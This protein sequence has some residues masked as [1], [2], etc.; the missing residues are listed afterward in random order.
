MPLR[1]ES[2]YYIKVEGEPDEVTQIRKKILD[3]FNDLEF[4]EEGHKYFRNGQEYASVSSIAARFEEQFD[5]D[6]KAEAYAQKNGK[7]AEYWKKKWL[8]TNQK[9]TTTG[10]Q[11]H[12]YGESM[13]WLHMGFP[14][15]ITADKKYA[16]NADENWLMP[17]RPK[18]DAALAF[19]D[20]LP[21]NV[22]VGLPET[23][24]YTNA[25]PELPQFRENYAGTFDLLLYYKHPTDP[26][27]SG[28][29]IRDW[30][31]NREI[32]KEF[33]RSRGKMMLYPFNNL[34]DEP[35]GAY[36]IQLNCYQ[37][38]LEDIGLKILD[39]KII[40]LKDDG[41]YELIPVD[42]CTKTLRNYFL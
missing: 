9:A 10:T 38:P 30:K 2:K 7:T 4:I 21:E 27:K 24:V 13:A 39:R 3:S 37:I 12:S 40:W 33:S 42:N 35:F 5:T 20:D 36:T 14:E 29:C 23:R 32:Y 15:N 31:T 26:S 17:T 1:D 19:W 11:V 34:Y 6:A 25:N 22:Y 41:T 16:Y 28:L 8:F 18:E